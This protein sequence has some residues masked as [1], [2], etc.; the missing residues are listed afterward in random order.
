LATEH[1][2]NLGRRQTF[3]ATPAQRPTNQIGEHQS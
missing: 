2:L 3:Y 1:A